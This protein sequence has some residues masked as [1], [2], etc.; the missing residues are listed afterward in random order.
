MTFA[1][2]KLPALG[3][4]AL[5]ALTG[6][7]HQ[8]PFVEESFFQALG[9]DSEIVVTVDTAQAREV[10]PQLFTEGGAFGEL[11]DRSERI[12]V[13]LYDDNGDAGYPADPSSLEWF[14]GFEGD[15][16]S[17]SV[18]TAIS[19]SKEFHKEKT[20]DGVKYYTDDAETIKVAVP[21]SGVLLFAS[22]D[23][24]EAYRRLISEREIHIGADTAGLMGESLMGLWTRKPSTMLDLGIG[25]PETV[26]GMTESMLCYVTVD[27][28]GRCLLNA[29]ITLSTEDQAKSLCQAL[30]NQV[31]AELRR[32][33]IRPD[34]A[35]LAEQ[36]SYEGASVRVRGVEMTDA[37]VEAFASQVASI[38]GGMGL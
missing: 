26:I 25:I 23:Y 18:N 31:V 7:V 36:Y 32:N 30:R 17:L 12:S 33:S 37:Q 13:A 29:D 22:D 21:K 16:G 8:S 20:E 11:L 4:A 2:R 3:L 14:G 9:A 24:G 28:E 15:Y 1:K 10:M 6:C 5:L 35:V 38:S 34:Y 27:G 19:W